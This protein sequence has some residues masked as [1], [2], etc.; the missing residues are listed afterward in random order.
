MRDD[1]D[2]FDAA[3]GY[4]TQALQAF[5]KKDILITFSNTDK[6]AFFSL[7]PLSRALHNLTC[8]VSAVGYGKEK[9]GLHALFDVWSCFKDLKQGTRNGKTDAMQ[10]FIAETKKKLPDVGKLFERPA[11]VLEA[12]GKHFIGNSLALDYKD[13]WMNEHRTQELERTSR[14]LWKDVYNIKSNE[15]VGVGFCLI[16]REE[17]LGHP[18]QDYLDSYQIA[19]AMASACNG[20]VSMSAYSARQSQ[21]EPSERVSDLRATLLGCEYDKEVDEQPFTAFRQLSR[22]LKLDRF[23]PTDA[24]FFVSGKGYP[25]KHRFG[26]AIGYPSPN[27][28]TRWK[29]PGQMLSKFDFYPQTKD[30]PRDPQTRI[31]FTE[32]LPIDVFIET[33]LLDWGEV[34]ARNQ[35]IKEV[36]DRCDV[37]YVKGNVNEKHVTNLEVGLVKKDGTRRWVRRSDTDVREKLNREYLDRTGIRAGCMGNIPGGEAFTT[38]EY[39]K[40]TFVGDVVIAI[41]QSYPLDE[42]DPFVVECSGDRYKVIAGPGK[43]V[44]KFNER[45]KE[46][47]DLLLESERKRTL[48][49]EIL[50]MKK[51]NFERIGEFA[52]NTNTKARLCDYLIVNEKIAKMMHI[53][54]G[55]GYEEDRSTD[56]H[57]DIVFNAP[58]QKLDVWGTDKDGRE[59]W[60]LKKGEFVV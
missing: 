17:M 37:I 26:D 38:P 51:D 49:A 59:H 22:E 44:K 1:K 45:K 23:R 3:V 31:A 28:K 50:K 54:C 39:V 46:A 52:I 11:L 43:T 32:T 55:S 15:R 53:A 8:E 9:E 13:Q 5:A 29:T 42:H 20:S 7:A 48:P 10:A 27:G 14:I 24:S 36:M 35:K 25:G 33:N 41:D 21:L 58:R 34:R 40:G 16:Q 6:R 2:A 4:Y 12:N 47:W 18:L 56:Y 57:I 30:E 60:I 19:W